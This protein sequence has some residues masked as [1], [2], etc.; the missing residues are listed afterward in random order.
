MESMPARS[1]SAVGSFFGGVGSGP[2]PAPSRALLPR[3]RALYFLL[4]EYENSVTALSS[5]NSAVS[6][7]PSTTM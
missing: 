4:N 3:E 7:L 5:T 2:G 1:S 6:F